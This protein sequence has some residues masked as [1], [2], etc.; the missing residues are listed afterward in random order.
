MRSKVDLQKIEQL[1]KALGREARGSGCIY[2]TGGASALL[3]GCDIDDVRAMYKQKLFTLEKLRDCFSAIE[4]ELIRFPALD[5][6][7]LK[8]RVE[9]FIDCCENTS[10]R[11]Q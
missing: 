5:P 2:F 3:I 8:N 11:E 7:L 9:E 4:P 6:D 10:E 1:M